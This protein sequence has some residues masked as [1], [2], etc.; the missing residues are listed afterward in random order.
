MNITQ[1]SEFLSVYPRHAPTQI[2]K[3]WRMIFASVLVV[4]SCTVTIALPSYP[5]LTTTPFTVLLVLLMIWLADLLAG[6]FE[7]GLWSGYIM[8]GYSAAWMMMGA[9]MSALVLLLGITLAAITRTI[10]PPNLELSPQTP[11]R[12]FVTWLARLAVSLTGLCTALSVYT[13]LGGPM[14]I[15]YFNASAVFVG[16][17][18]LGAGFAASQLVGVFLLYMG[19][20][21][22]TEVRK[23][24]LRPQAWPTELMLMLVALLIP[25]GQTML[26]EAFTGVVMLMISLQALRYRQVQRTRLQLVQR[27]RELSMINNIGQTLSANLLI[28]EQLRVIYNHVR[29]LMPA[30]T[31]FIALYDDNTNTLEFRL[32][33]ERDQ[34]LNWTPRLLNRNQNTDYVIRSKKPLLMRATDE[35]KRIQLNIEADDGP[36]LVFL[37]APLVIG[38]KVIGI[39]AVMNDENET[40]LDETD[41][42]VLATVASQAALAIRNAI[43]FNRSTEMADNLRMINDSVQS[44]MFNFD[45]KESMRASLETALK[46]T[47]GERAAI[48]RIDINQRRNFLLQEAL[49]LSDDFKRTVEQLAYLP[50]L[51]QNGARVVPDVQGDPELMRLGTLGGFRSFVEMPLRSGNTVIGFLAVYHPKPH[52]F[53]KSQLDL[54]EMLAYHVTSAM[55]NA[56]LLKALEV[57]AAEQSQLLH[58]SRISSESLDVGRVITAVSD[59]IQQMVNMDYLQVGLLAYDRPMLQFY[60][61]NEH[62]PHHMTAN[63]ALLA[64]LPEVERMYMRTQS[65]APIIYQ[66]DARGSITNSQES[67]SSPFIID[68]IRLNQLSTL[69]LMPLV[70]NNTLLGVMLLGVQQ[71]NFSDST[72]R[73]IEMSVNQVGPQLYNAR[74]Y[75]ITEQQRNKGLE[76]LNLLEML[77]QHITES[78]EQTRLI[79]NILQATIAATNGD[80]ASLCMRTDNSDLWVVRRLRGPD[81][82]WVEQND[83]RNYSDGVIGHV[84]RTGEAMIVH[85]TRHEPLYQPS[86]TG[87]YQ[88]EICVPLLKDNAPIGVLNVESH[89]VD[90]FKAEQVR[91]LKNLAGHAVISIDNA[92][93]LAERDTQVRTL[94]ELRQLAVDIDNAADVKDVARLILRT[95]FKIFAPRDAALFQYDAQQKGVRILAGLRQGRH[96]QTLLQETWITP[97]VA[98]EVVN[99]GKMRFIPDLHKDRLTYVDSLDYQS[100]IAVPLLRGN[101]VHEVLCLAFPTLHLLSE[102]EQNTLDVLMWQSAGHLETAMLNQRIRSGNISMRAILDTTR[103]GVMLLNNDGLLLEANPSASQLL[104]VSLE[105]YK[106]MPL[107]AILLSQTD[108]DPLSS[109]GYGPT[110]INE[111]IDTLKNHP[112]KV[113]RREFQRNTRGRLLHLEELGSPVLSADGSVQGR[114]LVIRDITERRELEAYRDEISH[115]V[116]HDLK[117]PLS[118]VISALNYAQDV[119]VTD[120]ASVVLPMVLDG[121][122]NSAT[123]LFEM[124]DSMLKIAKMEKQE[125]PLKLESTSLADLAE[126][127]RKALINTVHEYNVQLELRFPSDLPLVECDA[128]LIR[129][130][131]INLLDN[132]IRYADLSHARVLMVGELIA[133]AQMVKIS[134][135]DNGK[136]VPP[137]ERQ[138]IFEKFRQSKQVKVNRGHKGT[139]LGLTFCKLVTET[140]GGRIWVDDQVL[141]G[142]ACFSLTL[143]IHRHLPRLTQTDEFK[144]YVS[145]DEAHG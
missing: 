6:E 99:S 61:D 115:M 135:S 103:D 92:T 44:V 102:S 120:D 1:T 9:A 143:P 134:V 121:A 50:D 76:Q 7:F 95:V 24:A 114:L 138:F 37:G 93:L 112:R 111:L 2:R 139:G 15:Y 77:S 128:D 98:I 40:S 43:L 21:T 42:D 17:A 83:R 8:L 51:Y 84:L 39:L 49:N 10:A 68:L 53:R 145:D 141:L 119:V 55:D 104:G 118:S 87:V 62:H 66:R 142:G 101:D 70:V 5:T 69:M 122:Y 117:S 123:H 57:Y 109:N 31:F 105:D 4:L 74:Q 131:F 27:V 58:L 89:E 36:Y 26:G 129:R 18:A 16:M 34:L 12:I 82:L 110:A 56:E 91:F 108:L 33:L 45:S 47:H 25:P 73:L 124:I 63:T 96:D 90:F 60:N 136:G 20:L 54:L 14:P 65:S 80:L 71:G 133:D 137:D 86:P 32:V 126:V 113:T 116:V 100:L 38:D 97:R 52:T 19:G 3:A 13:V 29:G 59:L 144:Q 28:D 132:A 78:L 85:N 35:A 23:I 48:Y 41:V 75:A 72:V 22:Q 88:S 81:G 94:G 46:I 79:S 130:A 11:L 106:Q 140:H 127:A 107:A 64:S 30:S 125:L 67:S